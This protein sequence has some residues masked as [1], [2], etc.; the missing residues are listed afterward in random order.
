MP[1]AGNSR[2][3]FQLSRYSTLPTKLSVRRI[4]MINT[5]ESKNE[6]WSA[7][8][9][10]GPRRGSRSAPSTRTRQKR[11]YGGVAISLASAYQGPNCS[12]D[13]GSARSERLVGVELCCD[14]RHRPTPSADGHQSDGGI[15]DSVPAPTVDGGVGLF[16]WCGRGVVRSVVDWRVDPCAAVLM[17]FAPDVVL[18]KRR[19]ACPRRQTTRPSGPDQAS[20]PSRETPPPY[21]HPIPSAADGWRPRD[22]CPSAGGRARTEPR[23]PSSLPARLQPARCAPALGTIT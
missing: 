1:N 12:T 6:T 15:A 13:G 21:R 14:L 11:R 16:A 8:R 7:A 9:I 19:R 20:L 2:R 17:A 22:L 5:T 18:R 23:P 3:V 4:V 10:A